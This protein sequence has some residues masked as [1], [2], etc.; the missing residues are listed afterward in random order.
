MNMFRRFS[1]NFALFSIAL[2]GVLIALALA[3]ANYTRPFLNFVPFTADINQPMQLPPILFPLFSSIW[4]SIHL[5]L[6]VYDGRRNLKVVDEF[7]SLTLAFLLAGVS[8]AGLL[9]L[10]YREVSRIL[11]LAF[12]ILAYL[13]MVLW[14]SGA[15]LAFRM[16]S[17]KSHSHRRV[18]IVGAGPVGRQL[19]EQIDKNP[20]LGLT[21]SGFLDDDAKKRDRNVDILG[22]VYEASRIVESL[23]ID[24]VL[25][26]LPQR[27]YKQVSGLVAELHKLPVKVWV[28]P[29]YFHLALHKAV[30]EEFAGIPMLDLRAPALN[31]YQRM[32]KRTFDLVLAVLALPPSLILMGLIALAIHLEDRGS[33]FFRQQRVGENGRL[34]QM[35]KFRT[36]VPGAEEL[37]YLAEH[38][39][40]SGH[41]VYKTP[42]DP[43][44]T[45]VGRFLRRAS[46]DELPQLFNVIKGDMSLIGPRP[47]IPYV[48]DQYEPWQ[49]QRFAVPQGITGWWQVNGRSNKPMHLHTDDDL[50]YVQNYS[51]LLDVQILLKTIAVVLRGDGA[52]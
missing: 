31:E 4:V 16:L 50:Y 48:V 3:V 10:S 49:R 29:D 52:F 41:L 44:V 22:A 5:L 2:D 35:I 27:A 25:I 18:L 26:A 9:Y 43:R 19:Q 47:E 33:V 20:F 17:Q 13:S 38:V 39:D 34:F 11:F 30:I 36:M 21:V 15:R 45:R 40:E 37:Q 32:L 51:L 24:D 28:I 12:L 14:R 8:L 46:L 42:S 6:S 7:T 1:V 23:H